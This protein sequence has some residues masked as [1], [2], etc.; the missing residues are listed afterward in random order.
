MYSYKDKFHFGLFAK[1]IKFD[2]SFVYFRYYQLQTF[3][4][5]RKF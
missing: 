5:S 3:K 2:F 4:V 1:I